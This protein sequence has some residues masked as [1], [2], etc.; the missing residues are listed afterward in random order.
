V[1]VIDKRGKRDYHH[2]IRLYSYTEMV[3]LLEAVRLRVIEVFGGFGGEMFE[4]NR[5]RMVI[6]SQS[7]Q[8][9][10]E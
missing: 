1:S 3:M 10:D 2:S 7:L 6:L 9:E 4:L 8:M 5:D